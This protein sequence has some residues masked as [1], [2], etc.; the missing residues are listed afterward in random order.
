MVSALVVVTTVLGP[1]FHILA[2]IWVLL[3]L[4]AGFRSWGARPVF[5][6]L[7]RIAPWNMLEVFLLGVLVSIVKLADMAE[8]VPG[9]ALWSFA[10]LIPA[11][12]ATS[13]TLDPHEVWEALDAEASR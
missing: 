12:A 3:P 9:I 6:W 11:I 10:L 2:L 4:S 7:R 1:L 5:R 8:I 13:A